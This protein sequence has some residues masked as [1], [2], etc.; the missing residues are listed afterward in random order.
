MPAQA[1]PQA[2]V[3]AKSAQQTDAGTNGKLTLLPKGLLLALEPATDNVAKPDENGLILEPA[4]AAGRISVE[5]PGLETAVAESLSLH[6]P[7]TGRSLREDQNISP[8]AFVTDS[9][10][11]QD[12]QRRIVELARQAKD[13]RT[14]RVVPAR[15]QLNAA[16]PTASADLHPPQKSHFEAGERSGARA[17]LSQY[18]SPANVAQAG[19]PEFVLPEE[20]FPAPAQNQPGRQPD[21]YTMP[22]D[23]P[24]NDA[25]RYDQLFNDSAAPVQ[26]GE[27][28]RREERALES[29]LERLEDELDTDADLEKDIERLDLDDNEL[30][31]LDDSQLL[32]PRDTDEA[33]DRERDEE[34]PACDRVYNDRDCCAEDK[35]CEEVFEFIRNNTLDKLSLNI[36]PPFVPNA[37]DAAEAATMQ[38][39][40]LAEAASRTWENRRGEVLATGHLENYSFGKIQVRGDDGSITNIPIQQLSRDD[41]C[42]V[43]AWW[44]LPAECQLG[45]APLEIRDWTLTTF[46]WT[47]SALC[48]KPLYFEQVALERYGHSAVP[49]VQPILSGAHF[50]GSFLVLPYKMGLN[51]PNECLYDLGYYRPG[52]C[53]PWLIPGF[54]MHPRAALFQTGAVF[55]LIGIV[56]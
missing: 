32:P 20:D 48:H 13:L 16:S 12:R 56:N 35:E 24:R 22:E 14:N 26:P 19:Q 41:Y 30:P 18:F 28:D 21:P 43:N 10:T 45:D 53:A 34:E 52:N 3:D 27:F 33:A 39:E 54:P 8:V 29:E 23:Q 50:F 5:T 51:T 9:P 11:Q 38:K 7:L 6:D 31:S 17:Q 1:T 42:F 40:K 37:K 47:A 46:T 15:L 36:S 49:G 4:A 44:G 25:G 2:A 55:G